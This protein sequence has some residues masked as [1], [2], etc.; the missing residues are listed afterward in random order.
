VALAGLLAARF[1][2]A[3]GRAALPASLTQIWVAVATAA[4]VGVGVAML[5]LL[6]GERVD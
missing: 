3:L 5:L 6:G 1:D 4:P 2:A